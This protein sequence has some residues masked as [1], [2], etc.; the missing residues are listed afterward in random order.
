MTSLQGELIEIRDY[1]GK[2]DA[3][4]KRINS[5]L[6]VQNSR[7]ATAPRSSAPVAG[8]SLKDELR[9]KAGLLPGKPAPH[10]EQ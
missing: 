8:E 7:D 1:M 3:W 9:R 2:L 6:A 4:S 10:R 5:R